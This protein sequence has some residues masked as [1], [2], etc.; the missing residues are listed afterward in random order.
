MQHVQEDS[1]LAQPF[2]A[3]VL[4]EALVVEKIDLSERMS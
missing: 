4:G 1:G 3:T 2:A